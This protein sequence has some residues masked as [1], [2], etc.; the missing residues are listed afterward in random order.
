MNNPSVTFRDNEQSQK[1]FQLFSKVLNCE[2][3]LES[4][5]IDTLKQKYNFRIE[6]AAV[7]FEL[8]A[9][10]YSSS[11]VKEEGENSQIRK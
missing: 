2:V 4:L 7:F 8:M 5:N 1:V 11:K 9:K 6:D 10:Y 3:D